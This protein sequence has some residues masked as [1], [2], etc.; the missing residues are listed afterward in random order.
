MLVVRTFISSGRQARLSSG[1]A[2]KLIDM[3]ASVGTEKSIHLTF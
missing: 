1:E 3:G 2:G